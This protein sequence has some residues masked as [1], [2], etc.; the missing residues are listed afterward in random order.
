MFM[1][2]C[3]VCVGRGISYVL[4]ELFRESL[5]MRQNAPH[6]LVLVTD[7]KALD[8]VEPPSRVAHVLGQYRMLCVITRSQPAGHFYLHWLSYGECCI[9]NVNVRFSQID[10][11]TFTLMLFVCLFEC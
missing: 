2:F 7:G 11:F 3:F 5:G 1:L 6:V 10:S 8:D 9:Y 4:R